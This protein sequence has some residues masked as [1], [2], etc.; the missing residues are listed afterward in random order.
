[1]ASLDKLSDEELVARQQ[2]N[3]VK[4]GEAERKFKTEGQEIQFELDKRAA[5]AQFGGGLSEAQKV[6]LEELAAEKKA[7]QQEAATNG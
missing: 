7:A 3:S 2:E 6:A 1:M 4:R 5:R